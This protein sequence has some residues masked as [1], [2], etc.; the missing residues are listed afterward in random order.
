MWTIA[1]EN[2]A[3]FRLHFHNAFNNNNRHPT[4]T[5]PTIVEYAPQQRVMWELNDPIPWE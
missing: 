4:D 3:V 2:M 5:D 1:A